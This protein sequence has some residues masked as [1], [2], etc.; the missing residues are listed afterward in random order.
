LP[1]IL[2]R[3]VPFVA[4]A[5]MPGRGMVEVQLALAVLAAVR[6]SQARGPWR[7]PAVQAFVIG[8]AVFESWDAPLPLT[9]LDR[10]PIYQALAAE[11]PGGVCEVPLGIGDGLSGGVGWQERRVLYYATVH[12]HPLVGGFVG[13]MPGDAAARYARLP[14]AGDLLRLSA[15][16]A[17]PAGGQSLPAL[18][19]LP[20]AAAAARAG[21]PCRYLVVHETAGAALRSYVG[22]L[23]T[24]LV[25]DDQG[26]RLY[27]L[28]GPGGRAVVSNDSAAAIRSRIGG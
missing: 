25:A 13:R 19:D 22:T 1:A 9:M 12:E 26:T 24:Q 20:A 18:P 7:A 23:P 10:P 6:I 15:A 5:R 14:V 21:P 16:Q 2:L 28:T 17:L 8:L 3:Y 27:R 11:P 4:N